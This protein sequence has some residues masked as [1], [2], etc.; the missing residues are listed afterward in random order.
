[1]NVLLLTLVHLQGLNEQ[2][3]I[4]ADLCRAFIKHGHTVKVVCPSKG[5]KT[6]YI[7]YEGD[8]G[9]LYVS[10]GEIEKTSLV[11]KGINTLTLG[12]KYKKAIK[13]AYPERFD[14]VL[15]STPPITLV[16]IVKYVKRRDHATTYLMLKDI[17]PQNAVDLGMMK[18]SGLKG[19]IYKYF[20]HVEKKL[21][22]VS[23]YIGTM[24]GANTAYLL[25]HNAWIDP[26]IVHESPNSFELGCMPVSEERKLELRKKYNI[27]TDQK[28]FLYGGNLGKP[29]D[30]PFVIEVL[31]NLEASENLFFVIAGN[32]TDYSTLK[33]YVEK[34]APKHVALFP[35]IPREEY[36]DFAGSADV[37]L[38]FLDHRFTIPNYPSRLLTYMQKGMPILAV[39]DTNSDIKD[40]LSTAGC[41]WWC[42]SVDAKSVS[43]KIQSIAAIPS[44][45]LKEMGR[46]G[47][48]YM[49]KHF[50]AEGQYNTILKVMES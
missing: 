40:T 13:A 42:E 11:K 26:K 33:E 5:E 37:G 25:E 10:T 46:L 38:I 12:Q 23:D 43:E 19:L 15:Y 4:Y 48:A 17:F 31:K 16:D 14:L 39:T 6:G 41:G 20:R 27:P 3:S 8:S 1:M 35:W 18:S 7:P 49:E 32:G 34:E 29:Q 44:D 30:I 36:E 21:Y 45:A 9:I 22:M 47:G 28:V 50:S 2:H 24:S